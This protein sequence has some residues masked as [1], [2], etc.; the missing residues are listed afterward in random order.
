MRILFVNFNL[1]STPGINNGIAILSAVLK[2]KGHEAGLIFLCEELGYGFDLGRVKKDIL[3]F[4][5]DIIGISLVETQ[6]K[7]MAEFCMG[8]RKYYKGFLVCG[9]PYPTMSPEDVLS[10]DGVDAVCIGE[11]DDAVVELTEALGK[12]K[13]Y[14][15]IKNIWFKDN[16]GTIVKNRL[17]PFKDLNELPAED[18]E[19]FDLDKLLKLKNYQLEVMLGR[20]CIYQC[21]YCINKS[22]LDKYK[23]LCERLVIAKDYVRIKDTDIVIKEIKETCRSHPE[24]KKIAFIDDNFLMY[25]DQAKDFFKKYKDE[26]ALPF[27]CN[28]NPLSFDSSRGW[29][30][31]ESGCDDI[32]FGVESG[33]E[34]IK[35]EIMKRPVTNR[36]VIKS[37]KITKELSL[38]TSSF[39]MVGLPTETR[40]EVL[41]TLRLNA[42]IMPDTV[43]VMTFYPF[44][45]TPI[46]DLC[47]KLNLIDYVKKT[48][49]NSYDTV[50]CLKFSKDYQLFL[51]KAQVAFNW[52]IN[53]FLDNEASPFYRRMIEEIESMDENEWDKFDFESTDKKMS[54]SMKQKGNLHYSKFVN[55][56][57]AVKFPSKHLN[58]QNA[59]RE[60]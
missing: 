23:E 59:L 13:D 12:K 60:V 55:R 56:S 17:R 19:L 37:F 43:K 21:A 51:R 25:T 49:L 41:E 4:N 1:G 34:R 52:Y 42:A 53:V 16:R 2:E 18:K 14:L 54:D 50:T 44:K 24:I 27:V 22:Y 47:E 58:L 45:N 29:L 9:G 33:S 26:I 5:P 7:Y 31:K 11:G 57:L 38:M 30:L 48:E 15:D 10:V 46:Y 28:A 6:F 3:K 8:L 39:N 40:D 36:H 20:G 32:R 35:R